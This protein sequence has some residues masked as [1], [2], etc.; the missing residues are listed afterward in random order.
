MRKVILAAK[1]GF[2]LAVL[3]APL[4]TP[5]EAQFA[6]VDVANVHQ[7]TVTAL[8]SVAATAKQVQ[9]Y[10]TQLQQYQ[11][12]LQNTL[13]PT[14]YVWSQAQSTIDG[15]QQSASSLSSLTRQTGGIDAYLNK[16]KDPNAY[17]SSPCFGAT[18]CSP[19]QLAAMKAQQSANQ[20]VLMA[21]NADVLRGISQQQTS[22]KSEAANLEQMQ[23]NAQGATGQAQALGYANQF[24][25]NQANQLL[26]LRQQLMSQQAATLAVQQAAMDEKAMRAAASEKARAGTY[27]KTPNGSYAYTTP[28]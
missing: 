25:A 8:Q 7:T 19:A 18:G 23:R 24:A 15:L 5:V 1:I 6:V 16:F 14:A 20:Q 17:R 10:Q 28:N 13:A 3:A 21:S 12:M 26:A 2:G 22:L 9:Q 11:N 4:A 27:S